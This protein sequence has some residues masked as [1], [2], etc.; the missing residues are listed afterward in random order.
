[1]RRFLRWVLILTV[2]GGG[3]YAAT[4]WGRAYLAERDRPRFKTAAV[5]RG[6]IMFVV[7]STGTVKPVK[8]VSIGT[9][10]SG[11]IAEMNVDFND[12]VTKGQLLAKIDTKLY[13][14]AVRRDEATLAVQQADVER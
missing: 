2:L 4:G 8:S 11:P 5:D 12:R 10:V 9:F 13:T 6:D 7:N 3:G 14:A 1:M